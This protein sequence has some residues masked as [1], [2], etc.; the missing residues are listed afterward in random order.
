VESF[1]KVSACYT[2]LFFSADLP[3]LKDFWCDFLY[4]MQ[5]ESHKNCTLTLH[6]MQCTVSLNMLNCAMNCNTRGS[7]CITFELSL[8]DI[9][10]AIHGSITIEVCCMSLP[11]FN[12]IVSQP[13]YSGCVVPKVGSFTRCAIHQYTH[14]AEVLFLSHICAD[15]GAR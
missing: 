11:H 5:D 10:L 1:P 7:H 14:R 12:V 2:Q 13:V 8:A 15:M 3:T 6:S 9:S 4:F